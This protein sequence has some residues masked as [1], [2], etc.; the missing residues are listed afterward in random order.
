[1]TEPGEA[2]QLR[3]GSGLELDERVLAALSARLPV[4][5]ERTVTAVTA[6][7]PGYAVALTGQRARNIEQAV[8]TAL[9]S[10][11][12]LAA[13]AQNSDAGTPLQPALEGAY[14]LGRGEA[15]SGRSM[16]ALLAAYRVG[17]RVSWREFSATAVDCGLSASTLARFAELVFAYIDQLSAASVAGHTDEL[18]TTGRVRQRYREQLAELLLTG[19]T[20]DSVADAAQRAD[21]SVPETLTA[22][23]L[24]STHARDARAALDPNTLAVAADV[25]GGTSEGLSVLLVPDADGP[26]RRHLLRSLRGRAAVVGPVEPWLRVGTS[27]RRA[28][29]VQSLLAADGALDRPEAVDTDEHLALLVLTADPDALADLRVRALA[30]LASVRTSTAD[31]LAETLR[32]WLLHHGRREEVAADLVVH[33]Q[34]VRYRMTQLR[35]LYGDKL[36]DPASV[37]E[38]TIAL[39]QRSQVSRR[40]QVTA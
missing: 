8:Q 28:A 3:F 23:L 32:S 21:W 25:A 4:V 35:E 10:F 15:R 29:R 5:A 33:P 11:L 26:G 2:G 13:Q 24:P 12:R 16:D 38:L 19:A 37:L 31:R 36:T 34:T 22:V 9:G 1:V 17:A 20:A 30:P 6:E 14:E 40:G 7:V 39:A 27:Y 18:E